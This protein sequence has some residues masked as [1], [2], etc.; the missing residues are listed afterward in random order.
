MQEQEIKNR[1][2]VLKKRIEHEEAIISI[3]QIMC[4]YLLYFQGADANNIL[5]DFAFERDDVSVE[6]GRGSF[7]GEKPIR[8]FLIKDQIWLDCRELWY[9]MRRHLKL[10]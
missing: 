9:N 4:R 10:L 6:L 2:E 1:L 7:R 3:K 8:Q 5:R